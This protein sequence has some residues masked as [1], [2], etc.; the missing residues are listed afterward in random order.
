[1]KE[2]Y[3]LEYIEEGIRTKILLIMII[4]LLLGGCSQNANDYYT[5]TEWCN[6]NGFSGWTYANTDLR[7]YSFFCWININGTIVVSKVYDKGHLIIVPKTTDK[8]TSKG[9]KENE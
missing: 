2:E 3:N 7:D 9:E 4:T 6:I 1:M 8:E 5:K